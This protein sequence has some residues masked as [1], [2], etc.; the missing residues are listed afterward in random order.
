MFKHLLRNDL[1]IVHTRKTKAGVGV[2][3]ETLI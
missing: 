1:Y 2:S 3:L